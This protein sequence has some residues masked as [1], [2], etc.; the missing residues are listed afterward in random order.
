MSM[1]SRKSLLAT[2]HCPLLFIH[3]WAT[4]SKIWKHQVKEFSKDYEII[5]VELPGHGEKDVWSEPTLRPAVEKILLSTVHWPLA[6]R[7][8]GIGWSLGGQALLEAALNNPNLFKGIILVAT[9][10]C[11]VE[12]KDFQW[13][14]PKAVA[15]RMLK[16]LKNDF[17]KTMER[18]YPLNFTEEELATDDAKWFFSYYKEKSAM[19]HHASIIKSLEALFSFDIRKG[20]NGIRVPVLIIQGSEDNVCPSGASTYLAKNISSAK[21]EIISA[22]H[23]PFLTR[24]K[25][26]NKIVRGFITQCH[27]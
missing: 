6:T 13:G 9:S 19:F 18:F 16:D 20:L 2:D 27:K 10:P 4:D 8:I 1:I 7:F 17:T 3:G 12:K 23:V 22:G 14:R 24:H 21:V 11:F 5:T 25:E 26:F 15:R